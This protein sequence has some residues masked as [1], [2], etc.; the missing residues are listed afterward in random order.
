M[1]HQSKRRRT[2]RYVPK[3]V[4]IPIMHDL[5]EAFAFDAHGAFAAM[6]MAPNEGAFD[7]LAGIFNVISVGLN[8]IGQQSVILESGICALQDISNRA[9][10]TGCFGLARHEL[11]PI[12]NAV[13]EAEALVKKLDLI[14]LYMAGRKLT[15]I[16]TVEQA[17][18]AAA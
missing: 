4:N 9:E 13:L 2:K 14:R 7:Q 1:P 12:R 18:K 10:R 17:L 15:A 11:A 16:A 3:H 6:R 5:Q 8:D